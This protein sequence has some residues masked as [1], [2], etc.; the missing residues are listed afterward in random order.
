MWT[1]TLQ[2]I[3]MDNKRACETERERQHVLILVIPILSPGGVY[4][5]IFITGAGQ[6]I[7]QL[8]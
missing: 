3:Q 4:S 8:V 5:D 1:M 7:N 6:N 2:G